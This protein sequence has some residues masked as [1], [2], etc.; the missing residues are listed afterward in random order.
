MNTLP[1]TDVKLT[2]KNGFWTFLKCK[3]VHFTILQGFVILGIDE[4]NCI[5]IMAD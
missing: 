2:K 4:Y 1:K 5:M 3:N